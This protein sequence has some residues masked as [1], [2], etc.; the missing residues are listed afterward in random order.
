MLVWIKHVD[1]VSRKVE[2]KSDYG[3]MVGT[4]C[5]ET[6]P[7]TNRQYSIEI[8]IP[9]VI[10]S[11]D[12]CVTVEESVAIKMQRQHAI[13]SGIVVEQEDYL[14]TLR[15]GSSIL[16]VEVDFA[17]HERF[18]LQQRITLMIARLD[19]YDTYTNA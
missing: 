18:L 12:I 5:S 6:L 19:L 2:C 10:A 8:D 11:K 14:L 15:L 17:A 13:V 7:L 16:L 4:W 9:Q 3:I 1:S